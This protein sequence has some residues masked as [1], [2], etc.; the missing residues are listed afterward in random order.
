MNVLDSLVRVA[1]FENGS[2]DM[3]LTHALDVGCGW[4]LMRMTT[5]RILAFWLTTAC[6]GGCLAESVICTNPS[7]LSD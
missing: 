4:A 3:F 2:E 5:H 7:W 6:S 1:A